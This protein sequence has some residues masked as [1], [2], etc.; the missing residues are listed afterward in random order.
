MARFRAKSVTADAFKFTGTEAS[1]IEV[2]S[3]LLSEGVAAGYGGSDPYFVEV[4]TPDGPR[5]INAGEW[6]LKDSQGGWRITDA[7]LFLRYDQIA[8]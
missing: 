6:A 7:M 1:A 5:Q 8:N 2:S 3:W 4:V